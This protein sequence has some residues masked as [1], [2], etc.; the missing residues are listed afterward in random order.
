MTKSNNT[1]RQHESQRQSKRDNH[2]KTSIK[3]SRCQ[4][5]PSPGA[6]LLLA[7]LLSSRG[8]SLVM[9]ARDLHYSSFAVA[10]GPDC[11]RR[12]AIT[13]QWVCNRLPNR[14]LRVLTRSRGK[15]NRVAGRRGGGT[16]GV[17]GMGMGWPGGG[18]IAIIFVIIIFLLL[19]LLLS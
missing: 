14:C 8:Q 19:W 1:R 9:Q 6:R 15:C 11:A 2:R 10:I 16:S 18:G 13:S 17:V 12:P 3:A 7:P 5:L 4:S